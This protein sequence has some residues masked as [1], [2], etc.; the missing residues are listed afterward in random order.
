MID[1]IEEIVSVEKRAQ[2]IVKAAEAEA[3]RMISDAKS[4][5]EAEKLKMNEDTLKS[6]KRFRDN[7]EQLR[8]EQISLLRDQADQK[9]ARLDQIMD[10][11]K[12]RWMDEIFSEVINFK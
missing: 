8:N 1:V 12:E 7:E 3:E 6:E 9:I 10:N 4:K 5:C 2:E 11:N